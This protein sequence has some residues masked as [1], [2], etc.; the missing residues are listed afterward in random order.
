MYQN[1]YPPPSYDDVISK[2]EKSNKRET[3][4]DILIKR[5]RKVREKKKMEEIKR[6]KLDD[7]IVNL[8]QKLSLAQRDSSSMSQSEVKEWIV[9]LKKEC[10]QKGKKL[11]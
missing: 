1:K 5:I 7:E 2:K 10:I 9:E 4:R 3:T 6:K 11:S 8:C